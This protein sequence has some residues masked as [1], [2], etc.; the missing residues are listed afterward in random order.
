[1]TTIT[2][3]HYLELF[4]IQKILVLFLCLSR[5]HKMYYRFVYNYFIISNYLLFQ[6]LLIL[7]D[8]Y[9]FII[10][11]LQLYIIVLGL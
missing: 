6:L 1:M 9:F 10:T 11:S 2:I 5:Y 4:Q 7:T 3:I 8:C